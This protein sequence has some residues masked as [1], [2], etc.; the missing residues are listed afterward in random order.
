M[1]NLLSD[2]TKFRLALHKAIGFELNHNYRLGAD[3]LLSHR[4]MFRLLAMYRQSL[5][6]PLRL[7]VGSIAQMGL[8][9]RRQLDLHIVSAAMYKFQKTGS[10]CLWLR[11]EKYFQQIP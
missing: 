2:P 4:T 11:L 6:T 8:Y 9:K 10:C 3:N 1:G 7:A 5:G